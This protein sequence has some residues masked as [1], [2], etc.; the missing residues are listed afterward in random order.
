[1]PRDTRKKHYEKRDRK[2]T[3]WNPDP[4]ST[5]RVDSLLRD[6]DK[7]EVRERDARERSEWDRENGD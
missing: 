4:A 2:Y 7:G 1:M 5:R 6:L 3:R